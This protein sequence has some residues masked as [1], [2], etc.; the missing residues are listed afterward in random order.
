V[1]ADTRRGRTLLWVSWNGATDVARWRV[2]GG[3]TA[4]T[5]KALGTAKRVGFETRLDIAAVRQVLRVEA[6]DRQGK[7][8]GRSAL[9]RPT[10]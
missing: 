10:E 5:L 9:V 8:L 1:V 3:A 2:L 7:L 6:L 4:T